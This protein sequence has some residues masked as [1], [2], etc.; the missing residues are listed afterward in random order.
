MVSQASRCGMS[1]QRPLGVNFL[2]LV[3]VFRSLQSH[4]TAA[5]DRAALR[6]ACANDTNVLSMRIPP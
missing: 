1:A 2:W 4:L 3:A 6:A 5:I